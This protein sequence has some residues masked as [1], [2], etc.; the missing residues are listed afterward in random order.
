MIFNIVTAA[1]VALTTI[2]I[3][4]SVDAAS[5]GSHCRF[6]N[7]LVF[8]DSF[9]DIG[10]VYKLTNKTWPLQSNYHGRFSNGPMWPEYVAKSRSL[11]LTDYAFGSATSDNVLVQGYTGAASD[12]PVPGLIQQIDQ[13]YA[14][15][16]L[17]KPSLDSAIF[18]INLQ[19]NDYFFNPSVQPTAVVNNVARGIDK[20][21]ALGAQNILVVE[22]IDFGAV[23]YFSGNTTLSGMYT[24]IARVQQ[25]AYD[26][27]KKNLDKKYGAA[28]GKFPFLARPA[29]NVRD[30]KK[31][32]V[33]IGYYNLKD[34]MTALHQPKLLK[35]MGI[36]DVIHGCVSSDY[37]TVCKDAGK[38]F[39]WDD[40]HPS[41]KV[42][43][44]IGDD[45][46]KLIY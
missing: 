25:Q 32:K 6:K 21:V 39:F 4:T 26:E 10:N 43:K 44:A 46:S 9:S 41:A 42:H 11:R 34:F 17:T 3:S 29:C 19:G 38:H 45:I 36:T 16:P 33:I 2:T 24:Q 28:H 27:L 15:H 14:K 5:T 30:A 35:K 12:I 1:A 20:L 31:P 37:K 18:V 13:Y 22:N 23:P 7:I 40:F 8:G